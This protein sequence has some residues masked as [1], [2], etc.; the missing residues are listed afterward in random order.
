RRVDRRRRRDGRFAGQSEG[1]VAG[2]QGELRERELRLHERRGTR[3]RIADVTETVAVAVH[4]AGIG[5]GR[6]IVERLGDAVAAGGAGGR[7]RGRVGGIGAGVDLVLIVEAVRVAVDADAGR[8]RGRDDG[9]GDLVAGGR[10]LAER[11]RARHL[12]RAI[13]L[14]GAAAG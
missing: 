1:L 9:E 5:N 12:A 3:A 14:E 11:A 4:L 8:G 6:A 7:H 2:G 13:G 10:T